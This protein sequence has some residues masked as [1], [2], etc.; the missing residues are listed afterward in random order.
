M[1]STT[2]KNM[3]PFNKSKIFNLPLKLMLFLAW[4]DNNNFYIYFWA[5]VGFGEADFHKTRGKEIL[6]TSYNDVNTTDNK[7]GSTGT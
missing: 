6:S 5:P 7:S 1:F 3:T 4:E 2:T